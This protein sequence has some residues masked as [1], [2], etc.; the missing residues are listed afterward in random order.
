MDD[1]GLF[2]DPQRGTTYAVGFYHIA[3]STTEAIIECAI[4][5]QLNLGPIEGSIVTSGIMF[6]GRAKMLEALLLRE[7][8]ANAT[9]LKFLRRIM[10]SPDR[11]DLTHSIVGLNDTGLYFRRRKL[12]GGFKSTDIPYDLV[13]LI[14]KAKDLSLN[15]G[16]LQKALG[17]TDDD[18][19]TYFQAAHSAVAKDGKSP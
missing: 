3:W 9:A 1:E 2:K 6:V 4:A 18:F 17:I 19:N 7:E 8:K 12:D 13:S 14:T 10:N 5:K 16:E 11:V 15:A